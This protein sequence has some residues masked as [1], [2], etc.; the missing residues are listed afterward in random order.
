MKRMVGKKSVIIK[1]EFI[2]VYAPKGFSI[3]GMQLLVGDPVGKTRV[4][5]KLRKG[6]ITFPFVR[7]KTLVGAYKSA[8]GGGS[9]AKGEYGI[10][11]KIAK[12]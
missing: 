10:I 4:F 11:K 9:D 6:F 1:N 5:L 3:K 12:K 8:T 7:V 2:K